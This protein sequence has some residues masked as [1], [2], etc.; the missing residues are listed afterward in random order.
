MSDTL[1]VNG[2]VDLR[3]L[4]GA[5]RAV[6]RG[7]F[8]ARL[9]LEQTGVAGE[10]AEAFN[11]VAELLD[12][13]THELDRISRTVGKEGKITQR[14]SPPAAGGGW[15]ASSEFINSLIGDLVQ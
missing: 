4:L 11:D 5:L 8:S 14:V 2:D 9:P 15:A 3:H 6:K 13:S 10:I 12:R 7:D 1:L